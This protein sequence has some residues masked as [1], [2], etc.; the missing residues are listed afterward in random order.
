MVKVIM[1]GCNG[2]MGQVITGLIA[3]DPDIEIVA[4]IDLAD[5]RDN[6]YPVFTDIWKCQVEADVVI[7]F[8]SAKAV[9]PSGLLCG[10]KNPCGT[11]YYRT[12]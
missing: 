3:A 2:H 4:G 5:N 10:K 12:E 9:D 7:D 8:C 11:V 1:H 6:G